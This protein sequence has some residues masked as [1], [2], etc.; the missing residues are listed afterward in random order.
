MKNLAVIIVAGGSGQRIGSST[1]KQFL[2]IQDK[3]ILLHTLEAFSEAGERIV[4]LPQEHVGLWVEICEKFSV[5]LKHKIALGGKNRVESVSSGLS[6]VGDAQ[7][8]AVHDGVRPFV[9][10][11][12]IENTY[13]LAREKGAA[14][15]V[16]ELSDTIR[17]VKKDGSSTTLERS[18]LRAV[19]TPQI[20]KAG[21]LKDAY[22]NIASLGTAGSFTDDASVVEALGFE[23]ALSEGSPSN[24]KITYARD[25]E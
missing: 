23:V 3:P 5:T 17:M 18:S 21:L 1:P 24:I 7:Y 8:V 2:E 20:F 14:I 16:V 4:V 13:T 15:P 10:Q 12:V 22:K 6:L 11:E 9:S 19:Q 25:L